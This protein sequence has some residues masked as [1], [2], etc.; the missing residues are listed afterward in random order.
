MPVMRYET[1][2]SSVTLSG[3]ANANFSSLMF[4]GGA[5][6]YELDFSGELQQDAT[7]NIEVG[8][9]SV[10]L[11]IPKDVKAKVTMDGALVSVDN[12]SSWAQSGDV[13]T[14]SGSGPTLTIIIKMAA[15]G[16]TITD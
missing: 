10:Q 1:G 16:L 15:G 9:G 6:D 13:Y 12:S 14:Q 8:A 2:A 11:I 4:T 3:L 7:V 5:G